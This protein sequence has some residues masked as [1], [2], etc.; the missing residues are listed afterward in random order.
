MRADSYQYQTECARKFYARGRE[1]G[2]AR[3]R[4]EGHARGVG[5]ALVVVLQARGFVVTGEIRVRILE[6]RDEA[7]HETWLSRAATASTL[8][9]VFAT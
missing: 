7:Q 9:S 1:D 6:R 8:E 4:E 5:R 2:L 3:G